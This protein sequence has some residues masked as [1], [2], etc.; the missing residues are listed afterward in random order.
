MNRVNNTKPN[1]ALI[2]ILIALNSIVR[3]IL[4]P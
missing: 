4:H 3:S 1:A 2:R